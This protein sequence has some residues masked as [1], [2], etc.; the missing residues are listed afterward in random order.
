MGELSWGVNGHKKT[1][2]E[3]KPWMKC[4]HT[5][6]FLEDGQ[7]NHRLLLTEPETAY[8]SQLFRKTLGTGQT[9]K[10]CTKN[11]TSGAATLANLKK[12]KKTRPSRRSFP[13]KHKW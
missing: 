13:S 6:L 1:V 2:R 3:P 8:P 9:K 12:K 7:K 10:A 4:P 11:A 5:V